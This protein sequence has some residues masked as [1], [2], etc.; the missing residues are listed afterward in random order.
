MEFRKKSKKIP[1][2]GQKKKAPDLGA[3]RGK[4]VTQSLAEGQTG[5]VSLHL[6]RGRK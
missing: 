6:G 5:E 1:E 3:F 4:Q 2:A